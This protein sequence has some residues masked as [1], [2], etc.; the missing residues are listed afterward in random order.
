MII[1]TCLVNDYQ[2]T[3]LVNLGYLWCPVS[4]CT[5]LFAAIN[6]HALC[7]LNLV[8]WILIINALRV[9]WISFLLNLT[10]IQLSECR[11]TEVSIS[12]VNWTLFQFTDLLCQFTDLLCQFTVFFIYTMRFYQKKLYKIVFAVNW[13]LLYNVNWIWFSQLVFVQLSES[14]IHWY[15]GSQNGRCRISLT[16]FIHSIHCIAY[17]RRRR[18]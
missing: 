1:W 5:V 15:F 8:K 4:R 16:Y 10:I 6:K 9:N 3:C 2:W 7:Y 11:F 12:L 14:C 18:N 17:H 13:S